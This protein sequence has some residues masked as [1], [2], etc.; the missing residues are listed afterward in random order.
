MQ[1]LAPVALCPALIE[2]T[3]SADLQPVKKTRRLWEF[4]SI[5]NA[6][7]APTPHNS[8]AVFSPGQ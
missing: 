6:N 5:L 1:S 4:I 8:T 2:Y 3:N 7:N